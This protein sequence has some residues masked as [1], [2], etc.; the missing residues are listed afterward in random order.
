MSKRVKLLLALSI[1][2]QY[3]VVRLLIKYPQLIEDYYSNGF[4][5]LLSK[6]FR[7]AFGWI[8]FSVGDVFYTIVG[9]LIIRFLWKKGRLFFKETRNFFIELLGVIS[10]TY[11]VFHLFWGLNYYRQPLYKTLEIPIEYTH[12]ELLEFTVRLI[13]K[14]NEA[15]LALEKNPESKITL[16]YSR[17]DVYKKSQEGFE[18][19]K[20]TMP[21]LYYSAPSVKTS[22]YSTALTYMGYSGYLNP[23][24]NEAQ[25]NGLAF[26]F[27]YPLVSCHEIAHQLGFSAENEANFIGFLAAKN[28]RDP[29]FRYSAYAY[30]LRYCLGAIKN[31]DESAFEALNSKLN[32]GVIK[33]YIEA[34]EFWKKYQTKAEPAFKKTYNSFL[35]ANNQKHGIKSYS[36]VVA[37][38]VGH[39][40]NRPL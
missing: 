2:P 21:S 24:T 32:P 16:P 3:L 33:N 27:K 34:S 19:L 5:P 4:Y 9:I 17:A 30:V 7:L 12:E 14:T 35:K 8:P 10:I 26:D 20:N 11:F 6:G 23:F 40:K 1:I 29:Y 25:V 39:Y 31:K 28:N 37:L 15:H 38:L 13:D 18:H 36:Y 22:L